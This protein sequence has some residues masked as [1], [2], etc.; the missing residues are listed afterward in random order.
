MVRVMKSPNMMST[1]GRRPVIAAPTATP[2]NPASEIGVSTTRL[3]PNSSTNPERTLKGVPASATSSPIM[4]TRESRRISSANASRTACANVSSRSGIDVFLHFVDAGIGRCDSE[5]H[6]SFHDGAD[7]R[8][9]R[10]KRRSIGIALRKQPLC[11]NFDGI[12][13][14]L[15]ELLFLFRAVVFAVD[16]AD[17]MAA[18]AVG[19]ALQECRAAARAGAIHQSGCDFIHGAYILSIDS[20]GFDSESGGAAENRACRGLLIVGVLVVLIVFADVDDG[21]LPQ[22]RQVHHF[23]ERTLA[24]GAFSEKADCDAIRAQSFGGESRARS[25]AYAAADDGIGSEVAGGGI[26]D[27]HRSTLPAAI[28]RFFS[29]QLGEHAVGRRAL[30]EAVSVTTVR[31]GDV[32]VDAQG[33]ADSNRD[34]FFAAIQVRESRHERTGVN[35][36]HLLF[37]QADAHHLAGGVEPLFSFCRSGAACFGLG[38]CSRHFCLRPVF[39]PPAVTGVVTPDIAAST[40]NMQAK[41]YLVQPMPRAAVRISLLSPV[42]GSGTSSCRP[43]SIARTISFCIMLTSN[44]ASSGCCRTNGPRD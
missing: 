11:Q 15:P 6:R 42:V 24:E 10:I 44:H 17:V 25:D 3:A 41:S 40:S 34:S 13:I 18:V 32:V 38:G 5:L 12:A 1:T 36:V 21:K 16:V 19:I 26:G 2:V 14:C 4:Q 43:R 7:F 27:M 37:E 35:L 23:V 33:F 29:Q 22:L 9:S 28:T 8:R 20:G 30:G 31:A 39:L